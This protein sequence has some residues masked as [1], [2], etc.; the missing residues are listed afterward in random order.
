MSMFCALGV[1]CFEI[2]VKKHG[3]KTKIIWPCTVIIQANAHFLIIA[4]QATGT[5]KNWPLLGGKW[6]ENNDLLINILQGTMI[7]SFT[8]VL[9]DRPEISSAHRKRGLFY[10]LCSSVQKCTSLYL[11]FRLNFL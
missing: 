8:C 1:K 7:T 2:N 9:C 10:S 5:Q 4:K 6:G 3:R 11:R